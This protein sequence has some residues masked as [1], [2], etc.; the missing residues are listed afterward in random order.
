MFFKQS[1]NTI[2]IKILSCSAILNN[3]RGKLMEDVYLCT[4]Q[5]V[6]KALM[7]RGYSPINQIVGYILTGDPTYITTYA[8]ARKIIVKLD[9]Y[10]LLQAIVA[11]YFQKQDS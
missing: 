5:R 10:D 2:D 3:E 9:R 7:E 8:G 11:K 1:R 6:Y 4:L